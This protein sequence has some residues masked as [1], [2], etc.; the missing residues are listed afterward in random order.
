MTKKEEIILA[1]KKI[2]YLIKEDSASELVLASPKSSESL[3]QMSQGISSGGNTATYYGSILTD[4]FTFVGSI[5]MLDPYSN[6]MKL[7]ANLKLISYLGMINAYY[8]EVLEDFLI[9]S[10]MHN[11][12]ESKISRKD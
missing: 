2:L 1:N 11:F 7:F 4:F 9:F 12:P 8:G 10:G 5:V 6:L 3:K